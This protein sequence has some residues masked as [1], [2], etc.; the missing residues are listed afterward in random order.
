M[1]AQVVITQ[2][3]AAGAITGTEAVPIVQNGVTVRTTTGAIAASPS[4]TQTFLT[5]NQEPTL[6]NSRYFSTSTG[7]GLTDGGAQSFYRLSLNG[8]SGSL[9]TASTG[10]IVKDTGST[11]VARSIVVSGNG[12][13]VS[14]AN[15]VSGNPTMSLSGLAQSIADLSGTGML[16]LNSTGTAIAGRNITGT[17]DQIS[18]A[19]GSGASANPTIAIADNPILPGTGAVTIPVGTNAQQPLGSNGQIRYNV[20]LLA[21]EGYNN[22]SWTVF[23]T[24]GGGVVTNFS[25]GTTGFTP[26][27]PTSGPIVLGGVLNASNG[28]TGAA[29][30]TGYVYGNGTGV[31]TAATTIPNAGLT[32]SAI[33]INGSSVSLGGSVTV[34]ATA[35]NALTIGTG[36][37]GTSYNGSAAVT[38]A[39]DGTVATLTGSQTL[40]NKIISGANNTLSSIANASLTNS[41]LTVGTTAISLGG[42]S[43]TLGGLTSVA[44]TQDPVSALQ[45]ATKQYVDAVAQNLNIHASC[46]AATPA[47]LASIT[48]GTVTYNNGTA[49]VGATLTLSVALTVL[50]G[51]TLVNG[52]RIVVKNEVTSA[53]NGI[54]TW[55]TGGT[56]LTRATDFDTNIEIASGDFT[57]ITSGTL[58]AN[59]GWVQTLPVTTV[60][61]S[62]ISFTQ[63]SGAGTYTAGTGLTLTG[64]QFSITSTTVTA[65]AYGS[66]T[67]VGTFTV[68]AQGQLTLAG[69][70]TITPAVGSITGLGTG[71]ATALAISVGTAG[72]VLVNGGVLGTPSSGTVTNLTGTASIN[73]NGTVGATTASTGAFTTVSATGVITSTLATGTAPLTVASTTQVAN[74]NAATAGTAT[75]ATNVA[76]TAGTGATNYLHF[77]ASATGNQPTTTNTLLT[78]NY[79]NNA[80]TAGVTGGT[81]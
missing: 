21:Y 46:N 67:A 62:P 20:D 25:A 74:L 12:L 24:I 19:D 29:T 9:E 41:S 71:V 11:V 54:Y 32:N 47:T 51:Y 17:A 48:G 2:L 73:I 63:F 72:S 22:G 38:I 3:P 28:G 16:A 59:T 64:T 61:T 79:T 53:N 70:T 58:Y 66:A 45:L 18:V 44:V 75:N 15:G 14:N 77:S 7:L 40:T 31:M 76:L 26:S 49:G 10:L 23:S 56:V 80:L 52:N 43:L 6:P 81:F 37:S 60:G 68:N 30:L 34:T 39:I 35:S 5:I 69:N 27:A 57:F 33:T 13:S 65:G 78:Y 42:T 8:A 1:S 55:A 36:L 50:D 4:Q